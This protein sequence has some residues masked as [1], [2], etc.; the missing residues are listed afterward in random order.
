MATLVTYI[1]GAKDHE[2]SPQVFPKKEGVAGDA[3]SYKD[4]KGIVVQDKRQPPLKEESISYKEMET[5]VLWGTEFHKGRP[6]QVTNQKLVAKCKALGC[7]TISEG[8]APKAAK[9]AKGSGAKE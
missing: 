8:E 7:F 4:A 9:D 3:K 6:V 1:G 5:Y 2:V